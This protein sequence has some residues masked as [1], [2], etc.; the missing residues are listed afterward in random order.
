MTG[1]EAA[2]FESVTEGGTLAAPE[3][4]VGVRTSPLSPGSGFPK[5]S[6]ALTARVT[7]VPAVSGPAGPAIV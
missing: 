6:N 4:T 1:I 2:P 3:V 7:P 5:L